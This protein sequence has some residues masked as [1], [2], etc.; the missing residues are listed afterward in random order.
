LARPESTRILLLLAVTSLAAGCWST[1]A[2]AVSDDPTAAP[3]A[4]QITLTGAGA[5]FPYP[6]YAR[7]FSIYNRE[8]GVRINYQS[9]GSGGGIR[10]MI[11][12]TVDFGATDAPLTEEDLERIP[13]TLSIPTVLGAVVLTYNLP[14]VE[15]PIRLDGEVIAGIFL[16]EIRRWRDPRILAM[17]PG[18]DFPDRDIIPVHRSDGSGTTYV[19]T[20]FLGA[21]SPAW[22]TR[23]GVGNAVRWPTGL[24]A[25]GNEGV[26]GQVRQAPGGIGYVEQVFA[27]QN[28]L[29][30]AHVRNARGAYVA[31]SIAATTA[32]A[33]GLLERIEND[34]FRLSI[35]NA[36]A[37]GAYPISAWTYL[38]VAPQMRD[39][40]RAVALLEVIRW[41]LLEREGDV[42]ELNYAPLTPDLR[43]RALDALKVV[44]CGEDRRPVFPAERDFRAEWDALSGGTAP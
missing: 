8:H 7:W 36:D 29:P 32:A 2:P 16:G 1:D 10:Q 43:I 37:E 27:R 22:R 4:G 5:T 19:F 28:R 35:V 3:R 20:D 9:I 38:L 31:P 26:T 15:A 18:V 39:C 11:E 14:G 25:R 12:G 34:D 21:V 6:I 41:A 17:N 30:M 13:G 40:T 33:G 44:T 42:T 24:G 23:V